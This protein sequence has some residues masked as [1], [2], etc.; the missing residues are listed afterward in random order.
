MNGKKAREARKIIYGDMAQRDTE[1]TR[2]NG[3]IA[4]IGLRKLYKLY[5]KKIRG[6]I[7]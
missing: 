1:Y 6:I 2:K 4:C 3:A 7:T 5:K